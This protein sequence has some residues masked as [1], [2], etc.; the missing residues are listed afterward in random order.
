MK[1]LKNDL[2]WPSIYGRLRGRIIKL[3]KLGSTLGHN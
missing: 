1:I 3:G 2:G